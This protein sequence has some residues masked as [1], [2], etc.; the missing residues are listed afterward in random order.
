MQDSTYPPSLDMIAH[1]LP[2]DVLHL[3]NHHQ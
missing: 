1:Q 2:S 3:I